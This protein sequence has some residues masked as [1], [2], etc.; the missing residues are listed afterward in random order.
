M[1]DFIFETGVQSF[2]DLQIENKSDRYQYNLPYYSY[3]KSVEQNYFDGTINFNSNGNNY[4]S[5]TNKL[6]TNIINNFIYNSTDYISDFGLKNNFSL[7]LKNL[8][9]IGKKTSQYKSNPQMEIAGLFNVDFS[10]PLEKKSN[11]SKNILIPKISFRFNPSDMKNYSSSEN[12]IDAGN[13]FALNR[14][15]IIRYI[16]GWKVNY[17]RFGLQ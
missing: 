15:G 9:S 10:M 11:K 2:E 7:S 13:V 12:K 5:D 3:D 17:T 4:L 1:K 6:E 8:N 16:G 14:L